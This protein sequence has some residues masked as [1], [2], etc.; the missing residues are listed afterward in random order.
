M[1]YQECLPQETQATNT[2]R[3][4]DQMMLNLANT[5]SGCRTA[6][7]VHKSQI[8]LNA[9]KF[10]HTQLF[11]MSKNPI[12]TLSPSVKWVIWPN[13]CSALKGLCSVLLVY[14][15]ENRSSFWWHIL[16]HQQVH[17]TRLSLCPSCTLTI[18]GLGTFC[19]NGWDFTKVFMDCVSGSFSLHCFPS[20]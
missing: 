18:L 19:I 7:K 17:S 11:I 14:S 2:T 8:S 16:G 6:R 13:H 15:M 1:I 4:Q 3:N 9:L 10:H 20:T 5:P 12:Y